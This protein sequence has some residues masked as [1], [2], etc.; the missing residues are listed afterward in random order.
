MIRR[1]AEP[2]VHEISEKSRSKEE[3]FYSSGEL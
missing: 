2:L 1:R 3:D